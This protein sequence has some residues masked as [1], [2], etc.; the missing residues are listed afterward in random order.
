ATA[1]SL[2]SVRTNLYDND[3][4]ATILLRRQSILLNGPTYQVLPWTSGDVK[5]VGEVNAGYN[6]AIDASDTGAVAVAFARL[7]G[8]PDL[9]VLIGFRGSG[10]G[11]TSTLPANNGATPVQP[12][13]T[14]VWWN[15]DAPIGVP[16]AVGPG[17]FG[18]AVAIDKYQRI[19]VAG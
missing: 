17:Q 9:G 12:S 8:D 3:S 10:S 19:V 5:V 6:P 1:D 11:G 4:K 18:P 13:A 15:P 2:Y 7:G 16:R 14:V